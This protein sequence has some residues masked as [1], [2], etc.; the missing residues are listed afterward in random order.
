MVTQAF[1]PFNASGSVRVGKLA[2]FL[3]R[4][5]HDLRVLTASPL[6]YPRAL[7]VETAR[8]RIIVTPSLDPFAFLD[9]MRQKRQAPTG[10]GASVSLLGTGI[11]GWV[12]RSVGALV[13]IPEPQVGWYPYAV[14]AGRRL[15]RGWRPDAIYASALPFTAHLVAARLSRS[16]VAPWIAEFRDHFAGNPYSNLPAW[17]DPIDR[18]TERRVVRSASACVTVSEPMAQ[19]LRERHGKPTIVV[20]NGFDARDRVPPHP[21]TAS[22]DEPLRIVYTGVIYPG[23]RDPSALFAA[24]ASLGPLRSQIEAVFY[25]QDLRSVADIA[26]RHGVSEQVRLCGAIPYAASLSEQQHADLLLLLLCDDAR[27]V[28]VYTGKLFE[29]VGAGRPIL[30]VGSERGV[31]AE[32]VRT[33]GLGVAVSTPEAIAAHLRQWLNEKR[34]NGYVS[35]PPESAKSGLSRDEQFA[36]IDD[37]L[38]QLVAPQS[39]SSL[40]AATASTFAGATRLD[41]HAS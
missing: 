40:R 15:F 28:G 36:R 10:G 26:Q 19:A 18:W 11:T 27:E 31:A 16:A 39:S 20:L 41:T 23:R 30:A 5:G 8:D 17:R 3:V 1:P 21:R 6:P 14:A 33:R 25:G 2:S 24:I 13:A 35:G 9:W 22:R 7:P 34:Q 38:H 37:L 32:L 12:S 4:R 29:Y